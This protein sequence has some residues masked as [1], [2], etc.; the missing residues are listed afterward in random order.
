M[1][2]T[3]TLV[4]PDAL[5]VDRG[6]DLYRGEPEL[7]TVRVAEGP[8]SMPVDVSAWDW[9]CEVVYYQ[10]E[11]TGQTVGDDIRPTLD[12]HDPLPVDKT[13]G[14]S[15]VVTFNIPADIAA[16]IDIALNAEV[17]PVVVFFLRGI[18]A[19]KKRGVQFRTGAVY[20]AFE[21]TEPTE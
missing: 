4:F 14:A 10:A 1:A 20:R 6:T 9:R 11:V 17:L 12:T 5:R 2:F 19:E 18:D 15:G 21:Y 16:N 3:S 7:Q 8:D 13:D